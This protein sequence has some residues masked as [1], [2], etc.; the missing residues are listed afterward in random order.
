MTKTLGIEENDF[1][2]LVDILQNV[3]KSTTCDIAIGG[4][5]AQRALLPLFAQ[6]K[7][8][9]PLADV[10]IVLLGGSYEQYPVD[11]SIKNDFYITDI[12]PSH[13]S[14]Y[15]G[16]I[17]KKS[18][19]WVDLFSQEYPQKLTTIT[20]GDEEYQAIAIESQIIYL[21]KDLLVRSASNREVKKKWINKL[22]LL[23]SQK[24]LDWKY[25]DEEFKTHGE[26][27]LSDFKDKEKSLP[28]TVKAFVAF[29][30]K[31]AENNSKKVKSFIKIPN[32]YPNDSIV[33]SN[34]IKIESKKIYSLLKLGLL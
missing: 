30:I 9:E 33:T 1:A 11:P 27:L 21:A 19:K 7:Q 25:M 13:L 10:D 22:E 26:Y 3:K 23:S 18:K 29:A 8:G 16:M 4:S 34:G 6:S 20:V 5:V 15:F 2:Y 17:H 14:Y 32:T 12:N 31:H 24:N 28:K